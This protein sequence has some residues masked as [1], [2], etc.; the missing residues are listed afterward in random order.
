[1]SLDHIAQPWTASRNNAS[2]RLKIR[3]NDMFFYAHHPKNWS[4]VQ[5]PDG[6]KT[7]WIWLPKLNKIPETAGVNLVRGEQGATD[8]TL[9]QTTFIQ[10]GFT[11]LNPAKIDYVRVY[12]A[13]GGRYHTTKFMKLENLAGEVIK[14]ND[15]AAMNEWLCK[16]IAD[17]HI[18]PPH[19]HMTKKI[20]NM[21]EQLITMHT[22]KQYLPLAKAEMSAAE[23][24]LEGMKEATAAVQKHGVKYYE[25]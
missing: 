19:P 2:N 20:M 17:G 14:K 10:R 25:R 15:A 7:K 16:L 11:V 6:K 21:Q 12:P 18:D 23:Q 22:N 4:C 24:L 3:S 8:S 9:A 13:I 1:M 5:L